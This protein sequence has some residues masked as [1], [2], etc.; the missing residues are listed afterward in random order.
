MLYLLLFILSTSEPRM[1]LNPPLTKRIEVVGVTPIDGIGIDR[2]RYPANVQ[3]I[4]LTESGDPAE[5]IGE[6]ASSD[7]SPP[8]LLGTFASL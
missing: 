4:L 1:D 8:R 5:T 3:R 7:S 2:D 6:R